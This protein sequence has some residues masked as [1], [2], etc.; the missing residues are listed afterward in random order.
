MH[1]KRRRAT[2]TTRPRWLKP[3]VEFGKAEMNHAS[4]LISCAYLYYTLAGARQ[5]EYDDYIDQFNLQ[6]DPTYRR[7]VADLNAS[8]DRYFNIMRQLVK[9]T[10]SE[11]KNGFLE[12]SADFSKYEAAIRIVHQLDEAEDRNI[13]FNEI[14]DMI[15]GYI[16]RE[17]RGQGQGAETA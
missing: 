11:G 12:L 10:A 16:H 14:I 4:K 5:Q 1:K 7:V 15:N 17:E 6:M 2:G 8:A 13:D 3:A 9:T